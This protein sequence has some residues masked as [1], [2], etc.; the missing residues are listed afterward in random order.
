MATIDRVSPTR[1]PPGANAGT[2]QWRN[3]LFAHWPVEAAALQTLLPAALDVDTWEGRAWVGIV[4][5]RMLEVTP[6][7]LPSAFAF[8][9]LECNLRT[10]VT[11]KGEPGVYFFSLDATS[12]LAV[13]AA[14]TLWSLPYRWAHMRETLPQGDIRYEVQ[15]RS[16]PAHLDI[17]YR[18][19]APREST[20]VDTIEHFLLERYLLFTQRGKTL[21]RGQVHHTP[22]PVYDAEVR[23]TSESLCRAVGLPDVSGAPTFAHWSPGVDVEVFA[24]QSV[25]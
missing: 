19:G 11:H 17:R 6:R 9:F 2:Q 7:W 8:H 16:S 25:R 15:R 5:F 12:L 23:G 1:R 18:I 3:L 24:L 20:R 4:P 14:Q 10:Y 22:Y 21:L 13:G